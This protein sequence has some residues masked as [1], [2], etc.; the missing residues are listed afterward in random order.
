[1]AVAEWAK[2]E[3]NVVILKEMNKKNMEELLMDRPS[4]YSSVNG[5]DDLIWPYIKKYAL[6]NDFIWNVASDDFI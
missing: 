1:M 3:K 6:D 5:Y 2:R 4:Y